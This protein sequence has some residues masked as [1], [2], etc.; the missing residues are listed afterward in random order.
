MKSKTCC[1]SGH[2]KIFEEQTKVYEKL[3]RQI[4]ALIKAGYNTFI[5][6]GALGFDTLCAQAVL[7]AKCSYS[8]IKL[9]LALPCRNQTDRWTQ[10]DIAV[11]N[12]IIEKSDKVIYTSSQYYSGCMHRRNRF[13]VDNSACCI[14]YLN[15]SCG[16]TAYTVK[17]AAEKGLHIINLA[18]A[19][20]TYTTE[21]EGMK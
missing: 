15:K 4:P 7:K 10:K 20:G 5:C 8:G 9:V 12:S 3:N 1:F 13:M 11:Y 18:E 14:C 6:G 21:E 16:G 19:H 2:R 17:Y